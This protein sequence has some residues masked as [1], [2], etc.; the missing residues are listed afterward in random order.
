MSVLAYKSFVIPTN[1]FKSLSCQ[2]ATYHSQERCQNRQGSL[3]AFLILLLVLGVEIFFSNWSFFVRTGVPFGVSGWSSVRMIVDA[4]RCPWIHKESWSVR[5]IP[6]TQS[7]FERLVFRGNVNHC[8]TM[9]WIV[10]RITNEKSVHQI[11]AERMCRLAV[12]KTAR[13]CCTLIC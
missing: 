4:H 13:D 5:S 3:W 9:W 2:L 1:R 12:A 11:P 10:P 6:L 8:A 7:P